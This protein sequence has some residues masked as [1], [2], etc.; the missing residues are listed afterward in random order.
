MAKLF[1][2]S[3]TPA[4]TA[5]ATYNLKQLM[6]TAGWNVKS[7]GD[8]L[9]AYS[10][11]TDVITSGASGANG[12]DNSGAWFRIQDPAGLREFCFQRGIGAQWYWIRYSALDQFTGGSPSATVAPTATDQNNMVATNTS[13][14]QIANGT[15]SAMRFHMM[16]DSSAP[17]TWYMFCYSTGG[18]TTRGLIA[19]DSLQAGSYNVLDTDPVV[20]AYV[21]TGTDIFNAGGGVVFSQSGQTAGGAGLYGWIKMNLAGEGYVNFAW[22][23][24]FDGAGNVG[25]PG[26]L[27][28][29]QYS[30]NDE[31]FAPQILRYSGAPAPVGWKGV[32]SNFRH[33]GP[34][35]ANSGDTLSVVTTRDYIVLE[36]SIA[37]PWDGS[38]PAN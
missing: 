3:L 8:G 27:P 4:T 23:R 5:I 12:L 32:L 13:G 38:V 14:Q 24:T 10:S 17:Y 2:P 18:S 19:M 30:G 26:G 37:L 1:T 31:V 16:A 15:E 11:S 9:S 21:T 29:S 22:A 25:I 33:I 35:R 6:K 20:L 28:V 34:Q 36:K 7:S